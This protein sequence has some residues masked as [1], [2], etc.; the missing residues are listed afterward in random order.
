MEKIVRK[1]KEMNMT[2]SDVSN[3]LGLSE[4]TIVAIESGNASMANASKYITY[5]S[6]LHNSYRIKK[7]NEVVSE[8]NND[9]I[10]VSCSNDMSRIY[11]QSQYEYFNIR[12]SNLH[13]RFLVYQNSVLVESS[14][15]LIEEMNEIV[16]IMETLNSVIPYRK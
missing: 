2:Q 12:Y 8:L 9:N 5:I 16:M 13:E 4:K 7:F 6:K 11:V 1:R 15:R 14:D 3:E 10:V